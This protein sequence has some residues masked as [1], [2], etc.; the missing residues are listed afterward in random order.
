MLK[1]FFFI[2]AA[3]FEKHSHTNAI[4]KDGNVKS[5]FKDILDKIIFGSLCQIITPST[6]TSI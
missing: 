5:I 6:F 2:L 4:Y 1:I 3:S